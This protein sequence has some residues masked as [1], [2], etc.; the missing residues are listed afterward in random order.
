MRL[1]TAF[2]N[3]IL[4]WLHSLHESDTLPDGTQL[5]CEIELSSDSEDYSNHMYDLSSM[6]SN[7]Y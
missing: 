4:T 5:C 6:R 1:R 2:E 3:D 7:N